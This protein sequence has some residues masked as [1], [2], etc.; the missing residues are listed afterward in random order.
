[1]G[2]GYGDS[3]D[4]NIGMCVGVWMMVSVDG[5]MGIDVTTQTAADEADEE[6]HGYIGG[7]IR[8]YEVGLVTHD[9]VINTPPSH[10]IFLLESDDDVAC[11]GVG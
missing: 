11:V 2:D 9:T 3:D 1:M 4:W 10:N 7:V 5:W 8:E 6:G